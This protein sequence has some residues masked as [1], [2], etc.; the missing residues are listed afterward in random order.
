MDDETLLQSFGG[1]GG[2]AEVVSRQQDPDYEYDLLEDIHTISP[3]PTTRLCFRPQ[4]E[5]FVEK[6][7]KMCGRRLG[8]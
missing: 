5:T 7:K 8:P 1:G 6:R 4:E 2:D 3:P